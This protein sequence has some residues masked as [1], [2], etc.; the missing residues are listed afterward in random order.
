MCLQQCLTC[1]RRLVLTVVEFAGVR[2]IRPPRGRSARDTTGELGALSVF[3]TGIVFTD[4]GRT[5]VM[6]QRF[7]CPR[8]KNASMPIYHEVLRAL[9]A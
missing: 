5:S 4:D 7:A 8:K 9:Y 3:S 1:V 2:K 6:R